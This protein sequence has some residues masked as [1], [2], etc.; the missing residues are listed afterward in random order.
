LLFGSAA[1]AAGFFD[2]NP[3]H[4]SIHQSVTQSVA[5]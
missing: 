1:A 3:H 2:L 5:R 4:P